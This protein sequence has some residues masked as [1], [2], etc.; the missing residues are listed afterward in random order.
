V[1][2]ALAFLTFALC[3]ATA[4]I[5]KAQ[6]V[7][8]QLASDAATDFF[9]RGKNL[10]DSAQTST[11]QAT[12]LDAFQ[13]AAQIFSDYLT[14]FPEHPNSEMAW[15]YLG[16][17]YY[18]S[19]QIDDAKRCFST[20][21]NRYGKGVWAARAAYT[22]AADYYNNREYAFAAPLFERYA[23][24]ASKPDEQPRGFFYAGNCYRFLSRDREAVGAFL[25]VIEDPNGGLFTP[26][27][28][29]ALGHL[30]FK[31]G[32]FKEALAQFEEVIAAPYVPKIRGEAA[33]NAS[34][35]AT[36]LDQ[37][38]LAEKYLQLILTTPGMEDFQAD[39]QT[40]LMGNLLAKKQYREVVDVFRRSS[41]KAVGEKEASRLMFAG[42]AYMALKLPSEALQLFREIEKIVNPELD[43]AFTASFY[44]LQC[45][46]Q[47]EGRHLPDQVDAFLQ[48]YQTARPSDPLVHTALLFKAESLY[49]ANDVANAAKAYSEI[50][51][52]LVSDEIRPGLLYKR[53]W[54]L[55]EAGDAQGAIRSLSE[56]ISKYP[57]DSR[58]SSAIAKRASAFAQSA[59]PEKAIA[60]FDRLTV[61]GTP[62][63]LSSFAWLESARLRR[64]ESKIPDMI[65][66]YQGLLKNAP[67]LSDK[68]VAEANYWIGWGLIKSNTAKEAVTYLEKAR[69]LRPDEYRKHAGLALA[70]AHFAAQDPVKLAAEIKLAIL[71][72]YEHDIPDKYIQWSGLQSYNA[73]DFPSAAQ[74][75]ARVSNPAEPRETPKDVWRYLAKARLEI[76][77]AAGALTAVD[78]FLEVEDNST[79]KADGLLDRGRALFALK[80][81]PEAR[82]AADE[83]LVLRPQGFTSAGLN[84]LDGDLNL[85]AGDPKVA[86]GKYLIVVSFINDKELKPL[87]LFKLIGAFEKQGDTAEVEKY[88]RQLNTE[89]PD[90]KPPVP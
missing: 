44:R 37:A 78:H 9:L 64:S 33:L 1:K 11:V 34:L 24:N 67:D 89:F 8:P 27:A 46:Y 14:E 41:T 84:L 20:L 82:K 70:I 77:D 80:R 23:V 52:A 56:F 73:R 51:A 72:K 42:R 16:N 49:A 63:E 17:S 21:L 47:I 57:K 10:Y 3:S 36:K 65:V 40:A 45:F 26:M 30:N 74:S 66:R 29:V 85:E 86:A 75:L 79:W 50:N 39:A 18:Q 31:A 22:L 61:A 68:L 90:W 76:G 38:D 87:A 43:L 62:A 6:V 48:L 53:G 71:G 19:G 15:W 13:R 58:V 4:Q 59:E 25:K 28:K 5:P 55:A 69:R 88:R 35:I 81:F 2:R 32:K 60:D 7:D 83:A 12:R 54:C